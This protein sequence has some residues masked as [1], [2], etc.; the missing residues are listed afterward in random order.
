[1][2]GFRICRFR[3][4]GLRVSELQNAQCADF[5]ATGGLQPCQLGKQVNGLHGP[6]MSCSDSCIPVRYWGKT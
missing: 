1:M 2:Q 5:A 6:A 4:F 3:V